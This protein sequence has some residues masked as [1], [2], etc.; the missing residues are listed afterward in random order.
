MR[1]TVQRKIRM[2]IDYETDDWLMGHCFRQRMIIINVTNKCNVQCDC[3]FANSGPWGDAVIPSKVYDKVIGD[4]KNFDVNFS[5]QGGEPTCFPETCKDIAEKVRKIGRRTCIVTNG[6]WGGDKKLLKFFIEECPIDVYCIS[7]DEWHQKHVPIKCVETIA[8]WLVDHPHKKIMYK[9]VP[10][11]SMD[12]LPEMMM[13]QL[14]NPTNRHKIP[15]MVNHLYPAGRLSH[16]LGQPGYYHIHNPRIGIVITPG[17]KIK[18]SCEIE[19][20]DDTIIGDVFRDDCKKVLVAPCPFK[21]NGR[22]KTT[23]SPCEIK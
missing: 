20:Q 14:A 17:G 15:T 22:C 10:Q 1:S 2:R 8:D 19:F 4:F 13:D 23:T 5:L 6:L 16:K 11:T 3:C 18:Q 7:T 12:A 9:R 21:A